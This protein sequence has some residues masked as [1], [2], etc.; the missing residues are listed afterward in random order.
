MRITLVNKTAAD[1]FYQRPANVTRGKPVVEILAP[2]TAGEMEI[3]YLAGSNRTTLERVPLTLIEARVGLE[4]PSSAVI[5]QRISIHWTGPQN[6]NDYLTIVPAS[7]P[8]NQRGPVTYTNQG[9][10]ATINGPGEAGDYEIR[11]IAGQGNSVLGRAAIEI[12]ATT[13]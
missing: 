4:P 7:S 2:M 8:D 5:N 9:S 1:N 12:T 6:Q 3:R 11:Y 10:P 13:Q